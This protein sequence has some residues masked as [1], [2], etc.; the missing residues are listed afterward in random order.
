M[1]AAA[2]TLATHE[3][4]FAHNLAQRLEIGGDLVTAPLTQRLVT[5]DVLDSECNG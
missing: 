4:G 2:G 5:H 3:F 1:P